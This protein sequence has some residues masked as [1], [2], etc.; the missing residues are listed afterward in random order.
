MHRGGEGS[1]THWP[2]AILAEPARGR[3]QPEHPPPPG[4]QPG[5]ASPS[6]PGRRHPLVSLHKGS[7]AVGVQPGHSSS[8]GKRIPPRPEAP[9]SRPHGPPSA[10]ES[11]TSRGS[12]TP[13]AP[14]NGTTK[15]LSR[16]LPLEPQS[17]RRAG[18]LCG[19]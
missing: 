14:R 11:S 13:D 17:T 12:G 4:T 8:W 2:G 9:G 3:K 10:S 15:A 5:S 7:P 1:P 6:L 19:A 18:T 16:A